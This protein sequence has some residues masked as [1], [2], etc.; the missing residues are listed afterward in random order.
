MAVVDYETV[1]GRCEADELCDA[2]LEAAGLEPRW[3]PPELPDHI[4]ER[5]GFVLDLATHDQLAIEEVGIA[6]EFGK[7]IA[8]LSYQ[9]FGKNARIFRA[10]KATDIKRG[11][12]IAHHE[13][14]AGI[15]AG[16]GLSQNAFGVWHGPNLLSGVIGN[17]ASSGIAVADR[18]VT[19]DGSFRESHISSRR[20]SPVDYWAG[21]NAAR[22]G[23]AFVVTTNNTEDERLSAPYAIADLASV[24]LH[25]L[26]EIAAIQKRLVLPASAAILMYSASASRNANNQKYPLAR[27]V[28]RDHATVL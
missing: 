11:N 1:G 7:A 10:T 13:V 9:Q 21:T 16:C 26:D 27:E 25:D 4:L 2:R 23:T 3:L 19:I 5:A 18:V 14:V 8:D 15:L 28:L 17:H 22:Q 12:C 24:N 20:H 6:R